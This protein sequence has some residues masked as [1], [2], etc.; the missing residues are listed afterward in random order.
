MPT[1][2]IVEDEPEA[3]KLLSMLVRLRGYQTTS[4]HSGSEA[5]EA[6]ARAV[7]DVVFLDLMLPDTNGYDVCRAIKS[8]QLT[9]LVPVVVVTARL[10]DENRARS[11][12]V[13]AM[14]YVPK[15]YTPDQI[16]EALASAESWKRE[17]SRP[18]ASGTFALG[19]GNEPVLRELAR[20]R[21][22]LI[23][24]TGLEEAEATRITSTLRTIAED[25]QDWAAR[26]RMKT[27]ARAHYQIL[28]DRFTLSIRDESGWFDAGDLTEAAAGYEPGLDRVFDEARRDESGREA[29]LVKY[30]PG[31]PADRRADPP[32][33]G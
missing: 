2:L 22:L 32:T 24:H 13:G 8:R 3:N 5:R 16:F 23:A 15:P 17:T 12:Q 26:R 11:F 1:A 7:P 9:S 25:A 18:D 28:P 29:I 4:A 31:N 27:V 6:L 19:D 21:C 20:L 14:A 33:E 10:A 30:L